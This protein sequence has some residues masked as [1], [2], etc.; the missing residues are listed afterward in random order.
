VKTP[1]FDRDCVVQW[2][3]ALASLRRTLRDVE[4]AD[5]LLMSAAEAQTMA[6]LFDAIEAL[7]LELLPSGTSGG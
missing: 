7:V 6:N 3:A 5:G 4:A 1:R 2:C